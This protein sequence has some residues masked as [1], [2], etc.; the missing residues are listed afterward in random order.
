VEWGEYPYFQFQNDQEKILANKIYIDTFFPPQNSFDCAS[1]CM[2]FTEN[3]WIYDVQ[4]DKRNVGFCFFF[5][6]IRK[7]MKWWIEIGFL[8]FSKRT[9]TFDHELVYIH[10]F[11]R[12]FSSNFFFLAEAQDGAAVCARCFHD[13][14][15]YLRWWKIESFVFICNRCM[16]RRME[17]IEGWWWW[18]WWWN[19]DIRSWIN[20]KTEK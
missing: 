2:I 10:G 1:M 4:Y 8:A 3:S 7:E 18:L 5:R 14:P 12:F 17:E 11:S 9:A 19:D 16:E 15:K 20:L 13:A 6:V